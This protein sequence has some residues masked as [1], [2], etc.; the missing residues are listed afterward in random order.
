MYLNLD[1]SETKIDYIE[2]NTLNKLNII[3]NYISYIFMNYY[4]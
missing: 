2:P 4:K 3:D 1:I